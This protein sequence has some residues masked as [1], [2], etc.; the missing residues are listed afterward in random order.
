MQARSTYNNKATISQCLAGTGLSFKEREE[1]EAFAFA[2]ISAEEERE[3]AKNNNRLVF[4]LA[5]PIKKCL[6]ITE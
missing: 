2:A 4:D 5:T 1:V 3:A 6:A